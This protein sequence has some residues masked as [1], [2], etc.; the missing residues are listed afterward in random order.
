MKKKTLLFRYREALNTP[1]QLKKF[2][3][4]LEEKKDGPPDLSFHV[5]KEGVCS[6]EPHKPLEDVLLTFT[7]LS[8]LLLSASAETW[9]GKISFGTYFREG[10][11]RIQP[12]TLFLPIPASNVIDTNCGSSATTG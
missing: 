9:M 3:H 2:L 8:Q 10:Q 7:S 4:L 12:L 11:V 5:W 1:L 6:K